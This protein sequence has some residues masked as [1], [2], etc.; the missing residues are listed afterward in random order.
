MS[1]ASS[2]ITKQRRPKRTLK[3]VE[4]ILLKILSRCK[5]S[6]TLTT[7]YSRGCI[8]R[9]TRH[10]PIRSLVT[11]NQL[12]NVGKRYRICPAVRNVTRSVDCMDLAA[13]QSTDRNIFPND[14][15]PVTKPPTP[16]PLLVK[17]PL[18]ERQTYSQTTLMP[19]EAVSERL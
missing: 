8:F 15:L 9:S 13:V 7:K 10:R 1:I 14:K 3:R 17:S 4:L 12:W 11:V 2:K 6:R 5:I 18:V 16:T 19:A